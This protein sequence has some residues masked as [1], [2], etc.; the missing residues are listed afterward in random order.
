MLPFNFNHFY[1][2]Y[3]VARHGSFTAAARELMVSQSSLSIQV[4][5]F[6]KSMGGALL[7]SSTNFSR[8]S[9]NSWRGRKASGSPRATKIQ[10]RMKSP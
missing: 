6:E 5:Q 4:K 8:R 10:Y 9:A 7:T 1:Y 2:F 3:E